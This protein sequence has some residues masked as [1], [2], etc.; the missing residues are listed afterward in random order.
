MNA[1][2]AASRKFDK[3]NTFLSRRN[4]NKDNLMPPPPK[5]NN[6]NLCYMYFVLQIM[7]KNPHNFSLE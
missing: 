3:F 1:K 7:P 6:M 4:W 5:K 2:L